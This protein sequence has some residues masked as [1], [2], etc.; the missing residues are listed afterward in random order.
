M[1]SGLYHHYPIPTRETE[2]LETDQMLALRKA[3]VQLGQAADSL[4]G[5][6]QI[7]LFNKIKGLQGEV[8]QVRQHLLTPPAP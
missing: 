4:F 1:P 8:D 7:K 2:P 3:S 6:D 5:Q